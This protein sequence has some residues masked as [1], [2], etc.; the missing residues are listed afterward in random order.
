MTISKKVFA[1]IKRQRP[2][3]TEIWGCNG[4]YKVVF[5]DKKTY[6]YRAKSLSELCGRLGI[7]AIR[8]HE[9]D[10]LQNVLRRAIKTHGTR[11]IFCTNGNVTDNSAEI[12]RYTELLNE[13]KKSYIIF[14]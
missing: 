10:R 6:T 3:I 8:K 13:Y 11:N 9:I 1:E 12:K 4:N 14:D 7:K 5:N 2:E